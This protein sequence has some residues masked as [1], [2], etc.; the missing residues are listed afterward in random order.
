MFPCIHNTVGMSL[1][2]AT[3]LDHFLLSPSFPFMA[4][5]LLQAASQDP[6]PARIRSNAVF[7]LDKKKMCN[8]PKLFHNCLF[9]RC[10]LGL[11]FFLQAN[12]DETYF[13]ECWSECK[14][15]CAQVFPIGHS[16][17]KRIVKM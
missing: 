2:S 15:I 13:I 17:S 1:N 3:S 8:M 4:H 12:Q 9:R 7:I 5:P 11:F 16:F 14:I 6:K 10:P